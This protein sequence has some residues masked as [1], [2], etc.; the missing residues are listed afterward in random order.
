MATI[1]GRPTCVINTTNSGTGDCAFQRAPIKYVIA[2]PNDYVLDAT[3]V[4]ALKATLQADA[5]DDV[6][7]DRIFFLGAFSNSE[8]QV[9]EATFDTAPNGGKLLVRNE[10]VN[11][12]LEMRGASACDQAAMK[13]FR[14]I[15]KGYKFLFYQTNGLLWGQT[16]YNS[17]IPN[18]VEIVGAKA[19]LVDVPLQVGATYEAASLSYLDLNFLDMRSLQDN[20]A[21]IDASGLALEDTFDEYRVSTVRLQ[22]NVAPTVT[23]VLRLTASTTCGIDLGTTYAADIDATCFVAT[24]V[25]TGLALAITSAVANPATGVIVI[26]LTTPPSTGTKIRVTLADVSDLV[27]AGLM[28]FE[29]LDYVEFVNA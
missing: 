12:R 15:Q 20:V 4:A 6:R 19:Q 13:T 2:V 7:A 16:Q 27:A 28:W 10:I 24:N 5:V 21:W 3:K 25:T 1:I 14:G 29:S 22:Q 18:A 11:M 26:T 9:T 17:T 23:G 8:P